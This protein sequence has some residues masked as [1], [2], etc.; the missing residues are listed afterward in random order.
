MNETRRQTLRLNGSTSRRLITV[1]AAVSTACFL[2][3]AAVAIDTS[4]PAAPAQDGEILIHLPLAGRGMTVDDLE[5]LRTAVPSTHTATATETPAPTDTPT[6][7]PSPTPAPLDAEE[8]DP[9]LEFAGD[10]GRVTDAKSSGGAHALSDV[11]G[12]RVEVGFHG[13]H[14]ALL[15]VLDRD[16][17]R[18]EVR[19][20]GR[21]Y[22]LLEF[23]FNE[24]R[25]QVPAVYDNLGQGPHTLSLS[26]SDRKHGSSRG[27]NVTVDAVRAPSQIEASVDQVEG[28]ERTNLYR[29][30][31]GLPP[32]RM[33][34][35]INLAAQSHADYDVRSSEG[36]GETPGRPGFTG[37][38]FYE[39]TA[40]YGYGSGSFEVMYFGQLRMPASVDGWVATVYHRLP[41]MDH[42]SIDIGSGVA[43]GSRRNTTVMD[44]GSRGHVAPDE[45]LITT[46]PA[47]DQEDV[48]TSWDGNEMPEPLPGASY[49]VGYPV[50]LH[51]QRP[52]G[53]LDYSVPWQWDTL[54]SASRPSGPADW[55][56]DDAQLLDASGREV[57]A[58][59]LDE[60]SDPNKFLGPNVVFVIA[61]QPMAAR[62][63]YT[64][65]ISGRDSADVSFDQRWSFTTGGAGA[66]AP[67]V[68]GSVERGAD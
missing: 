34:R 29:D 21:S 44:F 66:A 4:P 40:Y 6:P 19:I 11:A 49:P 32:V 16:G 50:S 45:R 17:G 63:E 9:A 33:D 13:E 10:W 12:A 64:A 28:L 47:T 2:A 60:A 67:G 48:P 8:A 52:L 51:I 7:T 14:V 43:E 56:L 54:G 26:V 22:G 41:Y 39:R 65:H 59:V 37:A 3:T 1:L 35:A 42:R 25:Y 18:A 53:G 46:F 24:R 30:I 38:K 58:Y 5:P 31:A 36:H 27:H 57:P 15:R 68:T 62:T 20:D 61:R 23:Y 55:R